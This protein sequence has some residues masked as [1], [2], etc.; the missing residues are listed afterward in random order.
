VSDENAAGS[1]GVTVTVAVYVPGVTE[2][3]FGVTVIA[4]G[5]VPCSGVTA[6]NGAAEPETA[7]LKNRLP[8]VLRVTAAGR[9]VPICQLQL[10]GPPLTTV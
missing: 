10:T 1:V 5:A 8:P 2:A 9:G 3:R 7:T 6:K 4:W